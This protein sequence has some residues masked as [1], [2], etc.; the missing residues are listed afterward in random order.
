M[1]VWSAE[2]VARDSVRRAG[3]GLN[4]SAVSERVSEAAVREREAGEEARRGE[5]VHSGFPQ[6]LERLA[7]V[8]AAK[9]T[10]WRRVA[11]LME[12]E[13]WGAYDPERDDQGSDWALERTER[14]QR[15]LDVQA[16][17]A[18]QRRDERDALVAELYLSAGAGRLIRGVAERAGL[19]PAQ[20]LAQLAER[21]VVG[22]DGAVSVPSFLP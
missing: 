4:S 7:A 1:T 5:P 6:D 10:E 13:G 14:R 18:A 11:V 9:H 20:V 2:D 15:Y 17:R 12:R 19:L 22:E 8:W 3:T 16:A 21:V